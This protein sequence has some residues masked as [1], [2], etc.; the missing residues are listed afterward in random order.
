MIK[1]GIKVYLLFFVVSLFNSADLYAVKNGSQ[2]SSNEPPGYMEENWGG[3]ATFKRIRELEEENVLDIKSN[4]RIRDNFDRINKQVAELKQ[5][6]EKIE[7]SIKEIP[8]KTIELQSCILGKVNCTVNNKTGKDVDHTTNHKIEFDSINK[9]CF[10]QY[11]EFLQSVLGKKHNIPEP[12]NKEPI[13]FGERSGWYEKNIG[14]KVAHEKVKELEND[15]NLDVRNNV[16]IKDN[17]NRVRHQVFELKKDI[18]KNIDVFNDPKR[19]LTCLRG[20]FNSAYSGRLDAQVI[21]QGFL[22]CFCEYEQRIQ[23]KK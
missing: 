13:N 7:T 9:N 12:E 10:H 5:E 11:Q 14:L 21:Q 4:V 16:R 15:G 22:N 8:S 19:L 20:S 6:K 23:E 1:Q 17:L 18:N 3:S 2:S